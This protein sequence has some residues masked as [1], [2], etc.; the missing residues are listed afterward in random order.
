MRGD[1]L[2]AGHACRTVA[3]AVRTRHHSGEAALRHGLLQLPR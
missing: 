1:P 2:R 3:R